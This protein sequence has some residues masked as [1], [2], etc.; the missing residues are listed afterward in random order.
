M[1][2][3]CPWLV[4]LWLATA[5]HAQEAAS[6]ASPNPPT[7]VAPVPEQRVVSGT[8]LDSLTKE[9]VPAVTV[10]VKGAGL[11][12]TTE[13][14]GSFTFKGVPPG[15]VTLHFFSPGFETKE[16]NVGPDQ[17]A[18]R[19]VMALSYL[20]EVV[21][22]GRASAMTRKH[23]A[24]AVATVSSEEIARAPVQT[25]DQA[26]TGKVAGANI[27]SNS[28][29]PGGGMQMRL[30]GVSTINGQSAPLYVID[31]V[32]VSDVAIASGINAVTASN[33]GSNPA[34]TQDNQVNRIADLNPNDIENIEILKGASAAAIY[35]S[36]ASNG[37][38]IITT[39]R[40]R[41]GDGPRITF[42]QR[43]GFY[44]LSNKLRS[45][46]FNT[47]DEAVETFGE[48]AREYYQPG[49]VFD[50]EQQ[51]AGRQDLST[52]T[53]VN[54]TGSEGNTR[55][56][57]SALVKDDQG[58]IANTGYGKQALRLNLNHRFGESLEVSTTT[59][60]IHSL[61]R[62]GISNNDNSGV[63][64]YMVFP[65][66]PS[67]L[68]LGQRADG[69]YPANPFI[70]SQA[71]PLQTA[72]LMANDE[73]VW[74]LLG[75][76][77]LTWTVWKSEQQ[78]LRLTANFGVDRFQQKNELLFPPELFFEPVDDGLPGTSLFATA[79]S[80][81]YNLGVN[82]IHSFRPASNSFS[83]TTSA[84]FQSEERGLNN[85]YII[86]RN[87]NAGQPNVDSGSQLR[88]SERRELVRDRGFYLQEEMLLLD[89]RLTLSGALRAEQSS[90]N[91]NPYQLFFYPKAAAAFRLPGLPRALDDLKVRLAYG[92]TGN[93]PLYGQKFSSLT[94]TSNIEGL[95]GIV[96]SRTA[97]DPDIRPERQREI[98]LGVDTVA[99]N[100]R[101]VLELSVYQRTI[102]DL[103]LQRTLAPSTGF[104]SQFFNGG[105]MLNRGVEAMVQLTP[106]QSDSF[107]WLSRTTFS[108]NRSQITNL[109]VPAFN[110]GG[111]GTALGVFRIEQG[112][113]AT[114]IVGNS[115][116]KAD[117]TCCEVTKIG[118][119]EPTFRMSFVN[120][121]SY[122]GFT[123][124]TLFDWQYGS[125][126]INLTKLLYDLGQN[127]ADFATAGKQRLENWP[128]YA[129]PYV[130]DASFLKLREL[131]L[132]YDFPAEW[133]SH[134]GPVRSARL[135]LSARNLFTLTGYS[136]LDP[137]V[138]NFGNQAIYRNIDVAP[139]PPSRSYWASIE[140]GF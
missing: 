133:V 20:E 73:D 96:V 135:S 114:Q 37:V 116:L 111:F 121:L 30:R 115:G 63:S 122:R 19:V 128:T 6:T 61:S 104:T 23:L 132:T 58:I 118:D 138:S 74:R 18:V 39:K 76:A 16:V 31:G 64:H 81:S 99:F 109:P 44:Q 117:G 7:P 84:G 36:K 3:A 94:V 95:P 17:A 32:I 12:T 65:F 57:A 62:R 106:V 28:G 66:T 43:A 69:T 41:P 27:Q 140:L 134:L 55:Y 40:G 67:F 87:L 108:L 52:E 101:A 72:A 91:G 14:D 56:F 98:E 137:E 105:E 47:V 45:R 26:L 88:V 50:H 78:S 59:N 38:V 68:D 126:A 51:L 53:A 124:S 10:S 89:D 119:T 103:L 77:D 34:P 49:R 130:E 125:Q 83:A 75:S 136:G 113:S 86:S 25:V 131:T 54:L 33:A 129:T 46:V 97:G 60:L 13:M 5:A 71:N 1:R 48:Q 82:L 21:V 11:R 35:G 42:T 139:F 123:L 85:L 120:N 90:A 24:N 93:Q 127:T 79:E 4:A 29:A 22:V 9:G 80:L 8:V 70:G 107:Q 112:A 102:S 2:L 100:G 92:E 15:E 110:T